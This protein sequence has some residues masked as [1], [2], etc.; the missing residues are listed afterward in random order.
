MSN[1]ATISETEL[2]PLRT[3]F[4]NE[5]AAFWDSRIRAVDHIAIERLLDRGAFSSSD[6][7]LDVG[8]GTGVAIPHYIERGIKDIYACDNS[9]AM[10]K[11]LNAKFPD[12]TILNHNYLKTMMMRNF[13]DRLVI[14][15]TFPHFNKF[16]PVFRNSAR[17]LKSGG[18][19]IIAHSMNRCEL[20]ECHRR[21]G[22]WVEND[23]LPSDEYFVKTFA[24][25]GFSK[26]EVEDSAE[27]FFASGM[28][29]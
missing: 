11:I 1:A 23:I 3:I 5:N 10:V 27:G 20:T 7:V 12:I 15:N 19:L 18:R 24:D 28:I 25:F 22:M 14:F 2:Q 29:A 8:S 16:E 21:K 17:Y 6:T 13:V 9:P 26:I 4:F